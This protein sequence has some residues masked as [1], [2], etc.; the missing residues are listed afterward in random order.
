MG[1]RPHELPDL[2]GLARPA[3][4][5]SPAGEAFVR[6]M[7]LTVKQFNRLR[8]S[9]RDELLDAMTADQLLDVARHWEGPLDIDAECDPVLARRAR[10]VAAHV[11]AMRRPW[12]TAEEQITQALAISRELRE[13]GAL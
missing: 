3:V 13:G 8:R 1:R 7:A 4:R 2:D 12:P 6:C 10:E 9:E 11:E 5:L